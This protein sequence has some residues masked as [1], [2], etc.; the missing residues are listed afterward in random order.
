MSLEVQRT[1]P[2]SPQQAG[3]PAVSSTTTS[4][5]DVQMVKKITTVEELCQE[6]GISKEE[7]LNYCN[8]IS[9]E[10]PNFQVKS[11]QEQYEYIKN[12]RTNSQEVKPEE[13]PVKN[14][15]TTAQTQEQAQAFDNDKFVNA[16]QKEK[17]H[18]LV[19]ELTKN[20][21]MY[22]DKDNQRTAE[23]WNNLSQQEKEALINQTK[24]NLKAGKE[25]YLSG[26]ST[27]AEEREIFAEKLM[28]EIQIA[29]KAGMSLKNF[30]ESYN[31][32]EREDF[33]Y[34]YLSNL[35]SN[36]IA[37][38][39]SEQEFLNKKDLLKSA[40]EYH[41][42]SEDA[43]QG[44][45]KQYNICVSDL[46][47]TLAQTEQNGVNRIDIQ[48]NYLLNKSKNG[49]LSQ[50]E[51]E[52]FKALS[53]IV[54]NE[55]YK[56][57]Q[58]KKIDDIQIPEDNAINRLANHPEFG[59]KYSK[60]S[61]STQ[62]DLINK[63]LL[64]ECKDNKELYLQKLNDCFNQA[65]K[66]SDWALA[67]EL[68]G[69]MNKNGVQ[70]SEDDNG[71][72][73][74]MVTQTVSEGDEEQGARLDEQFAGFKS[75]ELAKSGRMEV[76]RHVGEHQMVAISEIKCDDID[77][78]KSN[79]DMRNRAKTTDVICR[80]DDNIKNNCGIEARG[81]ALK[82]IGELSHNKDAQI[83]VFKNQ[84]SDKIPELIEIGADVVSKLL[85]D[86]QT[87]GFKF[88]KDI[89][90]G[91]SDDWTKKIE[92]IL[93]DQI[94]KC[95]KSNQLDMHKEIMT[96]K[97]SD[98]IEHAAG[99][100]KDYDKSIQNEALDSVYKTGNTSAYEIAIDGL[101][102]KY[103]NANVAAI[104]YGQDE[105]FKTELGRVMFESLEQEDKD[106]ILRLQSGKL[107]YAELQKLPASKRNEYYLSLYKKAGSSQK[108]AYIKKIPNGSMKKMMLKMIA[109]MDPTFFDYMIRDDADIAENI[110][111]MN[112]SESVN[113]KIKNIAEQKYRANNS[114]TK[115]VENANKE[116]KISNVTNPISDK[117]NKEKERKIFI[118]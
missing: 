27:N 42:Q 76:R 85:K 30:E 107:T 87:E 82:T 10:D 75:K 66:N 24:E 106:Y 9:E 118:A 64:N 18:M 44:K 69:L 36:N 25:K 61:V 80:V 13:Q 2:I 89:A 115:I 43:K 62:K 6:L 92:K 20:K 45:E 73:L 28:T 90:Q 96:S 59:D 84:Q 110:L 98:V 50:F 12:L 3:K 16:D 109:T 93:S 26:M 86:N 104:P 117:P 51:Q 95:D 56:N 83:Y 72:K 70:I 105:V 21:F 32:D 38:S 46:P 7:Y 111:K 14:D 71:A 116:E 55:V 41:L 37:L 74:A 8:D 78:Q 34:S 49:N 29:N 33:K 19:E 100:V 113:N 54:N 103:A 60:S 99:N 22:A 114:Y 31:A 81:Y 57:A 1:N 88:T 108:L 23:D 77:I 68:A 47:D 102:S 97:Y 94:S 67:Q 58:N 4:S 11:L 17:F 91:L 63:A 53:E 79:V 48:Y 15:D 65:I 40:V 5:N 101:V 52:Q 35:K 39:D 112:I